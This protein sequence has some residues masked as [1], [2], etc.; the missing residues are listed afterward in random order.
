M[1]WGSYALLQST[2]Y[3]HSLSPHPASY[4]ALIYNA[5]HWICFPLAQPSVLPLVLRANAGRNKL[6]T[7]ARQRPPKTPRLSSYFQASAASLASP[8]LLLSLPVFCPAFPVTLAS[9]WPHSCDFQHFL[10]LTWTEENGR[11]GRDNA[12]K[13]S[14][15]EFFH[16]GKK[17]SAVC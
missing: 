2:I 1:P 3:V 17:Q 7:P 9:L 8:W 16:E 6:P 11:Q 14:K 13:I 15:V 12:S 4:P 10:A 5:G